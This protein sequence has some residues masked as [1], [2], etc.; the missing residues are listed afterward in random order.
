MPEAQK[1]E[2]QVEEMNLMPGRVDFLKKVVPFLEVIFFV[3]KKGANY[4][5]PHL[6]LPGNVFLNMLFRGSPP[7]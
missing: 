7:K 4:N 2:T 1:V 6:T 3:K 5:K